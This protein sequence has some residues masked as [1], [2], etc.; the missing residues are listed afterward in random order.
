VDVGRE[1]GGI[2]RVVEIL[3]D[4]TAAFTYDFRNRFGLG[5]DDLGTTVPWHEVVY[6]VSVLVRDPSSWLQTSL[7]GWH[8][9]VSYE[10]AALAATYDLHAQVHSKRKPKPYPRPW[11]GDT[12]KRKG[13]VRTDARDIL[14]RA[15]RGEFKWQ[16]RRTPT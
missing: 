9:P 14:A 2:I 1:P 13:T 11:S 3:D 10:W 8:H 7:N 16:N 5:L 4:H 6:L 15:R 12:E